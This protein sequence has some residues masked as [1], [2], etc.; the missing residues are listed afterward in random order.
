MLEIVPRS[1]PHD[2]DGFAPEF[3]GGA[4]LWKSASIPSPNIR[5]SLREATVLT[6]A[7]T[8]GAVVPMADSGHFPRTAR[9]KRRVSIFEVSFLAAE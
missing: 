3:D 5:Q 4:A 8:A 9:S 7:V 1:G 2:I 6:M